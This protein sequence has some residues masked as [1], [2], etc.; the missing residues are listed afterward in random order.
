ME[1]ATLFSIWL[2]MTSGSEAV[3]VFKD[4]M[5]LVTSLLVQEMEDKQGIGDIGLAWIKSGDGWDLVKQGAK[6]ELSIWA[7]AVLVSAVV[8]P[9]GADEV[10]AGGLSIED[11]KHSRIV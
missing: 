6:W 1:N 4:V 9:L 3:L 11:D 2:E 7:L 10:F 5:R 8:D